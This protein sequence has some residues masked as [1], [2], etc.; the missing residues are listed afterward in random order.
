MLKDK[1]SSRATQSR[2]KRAKRA[3]GEPTPR[4]EHSVTDRIVA[5]FDSIPRQM[6]VAARYVLDYPEDVALLTM[7]E[8]AKR[9]NVPPATMTRL[10]S[11]RACFSLI[12]SSDGT[13]YPMDFPV[14]VSAWAS[15]IRVVGSWRNSHTMSLKFFCRGRGVSPRWVAT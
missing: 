12:M 11:P 8:Q 7:R 1:E 5:A 15:I 6:Q 9:A 3:G 2:P 14:P 10:A 13:R 4:P